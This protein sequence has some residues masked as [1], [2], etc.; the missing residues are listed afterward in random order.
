[1]PGSRC[2]NQWSGFGPRRTRRRIGFA[3]FLGSNLR[4]NGPYHVYSFWALY[5]KA[6]TAILARGEPHQRW[7]HK[8]VEAALSGGI[9]MR[10]RGDAPVKV[11]TVL[12]FSLPGR[13]GNHV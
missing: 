11:W 2:R 7:L 1:M 12:G 6:P 4:T 5:G 10:N 3:G 9:A 8:F 13:S